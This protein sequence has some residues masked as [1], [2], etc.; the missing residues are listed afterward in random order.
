MHG[1][2][3]SSKNQ[4]FSIVE[5]MVVVSIMAILSTIGLVV[6]QGLQDSAKKAKVK[7]DFRSMQNAV[8]QMRITQQRT[9]AQITTDQCLPLTNRLCTN[10]SSTGAWAAENCYK[11]NVLTDT[12]C[13]TDLKNA[14]AK[15]NSSPLPTDPWGN[16]YLFDENEYEGG[17]RDNCWHTDRFF[18]AGPDHIFDQSCITSTDD[19][20]YAVPFFIC[21]SETSSTDIIP[22]AVPILKCKPGQPKL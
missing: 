7:R 20:T 15:V 11:K 17:G 13:Q 16:L 18:S 9:L 8:E 3:L 1:P 21:N 2:N 22:I 19:I 12:T 4:G 14:W 5:L 10:V 6:F